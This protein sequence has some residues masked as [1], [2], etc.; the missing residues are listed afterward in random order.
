MERQADI[1]EADKEVSK[2]KMMSAVNMILENRTEGNWYIV[3][4]LLWDNGLEFQL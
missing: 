1:E 2:F 4:P 3:V